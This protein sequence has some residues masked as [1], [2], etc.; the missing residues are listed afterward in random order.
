LSGIIYLDA[1]ENGRLDAGETVVA[2]VTV[3]LD[4]RFSVRTDSNG[5]YDF[6]AV[7]SGHHVITVQSDNL[8]L[9][10]TMTSSGRTEVEVSTRNRTEI[11][12]GALRIK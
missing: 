1:N 2:N 5:R 12:V 10:W 6:P 3:I 4:G 7:A 8:P 9:P 11:D